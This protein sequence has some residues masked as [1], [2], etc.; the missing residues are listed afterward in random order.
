MFNK[1]VERH[2]EEENDMTEGNACEEH[3]WAWWASVPTCSPK[4]VF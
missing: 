3:G 2:S 1:D 4:L